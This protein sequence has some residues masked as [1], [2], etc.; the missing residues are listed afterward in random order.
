MG[1]KKRAAKVQVTSEDSAWMRNILIDALDAF[2][3]E[4]QRSTAA[5]IRQGE[6]CVESTPELDSVVEAFTMAIARGCVPHPESV[7]IVKR[8]LEDNAVKDAALSEII[9]GKGVSEAERIQAVGRTI[10]DRK[11]ALEDLR[12][13]LERQAGSRVDTFLARSGAGQ[14]G[15]INNVSVMSFGIDARELGIPLREPQEPSE[16]S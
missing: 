1:G 10:G 2:T 6:I 9:D 4:K 3:R 15:I 12:S 13:E 5:G 8:R 16:A 7:E 14:A 11:K